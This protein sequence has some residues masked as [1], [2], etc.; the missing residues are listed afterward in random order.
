MSSNDT[1]TIELTNT[2]DKVP[3]FKKKPRQNK[4]LRKRKQFSPEGSADEAG[5]SA[6]V[7]K[8]RKIDPNSPFVQISRKEKQK[9]DIS[10]KFSSNQLAV[11]L[12]GQDI[13]TRSAEWDTEF[14]RDA[15]ALLEKKIAAEDVSPYLCCF[16]IAP[17]YGWA[18]ILIS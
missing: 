7:T 6:V 17:A 9:E 4:N 18:H 14:D 3:F 1:S 13:A 5:K 16:A 11:P 15:Q 10:V 8:E 2:T 12:T